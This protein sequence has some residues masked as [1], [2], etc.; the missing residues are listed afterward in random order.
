MDAAQAAAWRRETAGWPFVGREDELALIAGIREAGT[1][2]GV[3]L[4]AAAGVGKS[5]LARRA[6]RAA[7]RAGAY[8]CWVQ[9]TRSAATVPIG[10][11]AALIP[12]DR[13]A[14]DT[15]GLIRASADWLRE[16]AGG[17]PI[18]LCVDDA[19]L[20]DPTSAALVLHLATSGAAFVLATVRAGEPRP[21][22]VDALW[23][24]A[25]LQLVELDALDEPQ[26]AQLVEAALGAPAEERVRRWAFDS[27]QGNVLYVREVLT[28]ALDRGAL[29][30]RDGFWCLTREPPPSATLAELVGDRMADIADDERQVLELLALGEPLPLAELMDLAGAAP[31][32]EVESRGLV[33]AEGVAAD[34]AVRLAH[35]LYGEVVR[36]SMPTIRARAGRLALA[37]L[38]RARPETTPDDQLRVARW[39]LDAGEPVPHDV[40]LEAAGAA[41]LAGDAELGARLAERALTGGDAPRAAL[42]LARAHAM[43]KRFAE[44]E[45]VLATAEDDFA[46][47]DLAGQALEHRVVLLHWMLHR[48]ADALA[49]VARAAQRWPDAAWR[50]RVE[51]VRLYLLMWQEPAAALAGT[52][53]LLAG[54]PLAPELHHRVELVR[55]GALFY[56]GRGTEAHALAESLRPAVP[57]R[58]THEQM[59]LDV[60]G[61]IDCETGEDLEAAAAWLA[62]TLRAAV[63]AHDDAA[64]GLAAVT[65]ADLERVRGRLD[66]G[67]RWVAEAIAQLE[68]RDPFRY[69]PLAHV[70]AAGIAR[71]RGDSE[72]VASA[73]A[74]HRALADAEMEAAEVPNRARGEAWARL[75]EGDP[76]GA[77][78]VLREAAGRCVRM[79][80]Y[81]LSLLYEAM[82]AGAAAAALVAEAEAA[83]ARCESRLAAC[84]A[85]HLRARAAQ[86]G[87]ELLRVAEQFAAAGTVRYAAE[88]AAHAAELFAGEGRQDSARRAAVRCHELH[89]LGQ[90]GAPP[91]IRG[92]DAAAVQLTPREEQF[93]SLAARGLTNAEIADRL[94]LSVRTV[95]SHL[96]RAMQ[97]L[98]VRDRREL[99]PR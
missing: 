54:P 46:D 30:D 89:A 34:S 40:A 98:G 65:L 18:V 45:A 29:E 5:Q 28:G 49:F 83:A 92:L 57:L 95:E 15:L 60:C 38:V 12:S 90:G 1:A 6:A 86:D 42:V 33:V 80:L 48:P 84:Y 7:E 27:S 37:A 62:G 96:Y 35:P 75:A 26:T 2:P 24:D 31:L 74:R 17:R 21:D 82:R 50:S 93:V 13:A 66:D 71:E 91:V 55:A 81:V 16:D 61:M 41:N 85:A 73:T 47:Q 68:R 19:Q 14:E 11:F 43:R 67:E 87:P 9:A 51:S 20:L 88:A 64:A 25:G 22:A 77:Q 4:K 99:K 3:V 79:P 44:A 32:T 52:E 23:K 56:A 97:K 8:A 94:V 58:G 72:G 39:L 63:V 59:A 53:T 10:A 78:A 36:A 76:A 69:L 70:V